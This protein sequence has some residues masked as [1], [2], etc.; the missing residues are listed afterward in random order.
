LAKK[1]PLDVLTIPTGSDFGTAR[2]EAGT[3]VTRSLYVGYVSRLGPTDPA[4]LQNRNAVRLEYD[5]TSRWSF[6]GEHG[7]AM[8][9]N[10]DVL[11]T[12]HY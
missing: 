10:A 2:V 12:N 5:L 9:S 3:Y 4:L 7:D 6:Q 1:L 8:N 11:W